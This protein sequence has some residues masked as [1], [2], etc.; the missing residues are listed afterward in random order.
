[1]KIVKQIADLSSVAASW[2]LS[3]RSLARKRAGKRTHVLFCMCDH[4]EPG[5]GKVTAEVGSGRVDDLL[6]EYPRIADAH[7]DS[8]GC[9]PKRTWFF[10]PHYHQNGWLKKLVSLCERGYGEVELHLHHGKQE[11]DTSENLRAT[12]RQCVEEYGIFGVFGDFEGDKQYGF[13]HGDWALDNSRNGEFCGVDDEITILKETGCYADF[14]FP[15][16]NDARP[17]Q[18]NSIYYAEDDPLRPKSHDTGKHVCVGGPHRHHD[19]SNRDLMIVAGP[20]HPHF[21]HGRLRGLRVFG[22]SIDV[23]QTVTPP[24]IDQW[25]RTGISVKGKENWVV[26]KTHTHGA[27]DGEIAIGP[28]MHE[29]FSHLETNYRDH[30]DYALHYVTS[31]ELYNVIK[32]AEAGEPGEDPAAY[33]EYR[34]RAPVYD[35]SP[36]V[37]EASAVLQGMV[38]KSYRG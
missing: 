38:A 7:H 17:K 33:K 6:R 32:A 2:L 15:C 14:T 23:E 28:S 30:E 19:Q 31:R 18:I 21:R 1:M 20:L 4:Y 29:M 36:D 10:P 16:Y 27:S 11:P 13:I 9:K 24:R 8:H 22:D 25:V 37:M 34:V 26:I 3:S 5:T 12:L 35:S